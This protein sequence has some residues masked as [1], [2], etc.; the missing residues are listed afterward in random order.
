MR[1]KNSMW[2][3]KI[4]SIYFPK[5]MKLYEV[6]LYRARMQIIWLYIHYIYNKS[7]QHGELSLWLSSVK[8]SYFQNMARPGL[9]LSLSWTLMLS[10]YII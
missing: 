9:I 5:N 7:W 6:P 8:W 10:I 3:T 2:Y 1:D 4:E